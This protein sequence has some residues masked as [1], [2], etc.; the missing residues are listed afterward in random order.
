MLPEEHALWDRIRHFQL[1]DPSIAFPFSKRL[2]RENGWSFDYTLRVIEE[3]RK[4]LFLCCVSEKGVTPSDPVDQA[5][6]LH[7]TYTRSYWVDLCRNTLQKEIHH[8]PTKGGPAEAQK[9]DGLY[10]SL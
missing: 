2:A 10:T 6:H 9:F 3:Y 5:W 4:F 7:L 8:H 1:D